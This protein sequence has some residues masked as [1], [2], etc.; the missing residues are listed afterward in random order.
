VERARWGAGADEGQVKRSDYSRPRPSAQA[1][2]QD[3]RVRRLTVNLHA[4]GP[5]PL[6]ELL[7]ELVEVHGIGDD[8]LDRLEVYYGLSD[9]AVESLGGREWPPAPLTV[10]AGRQA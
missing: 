10:L 9:Y 3:P 6:G 2:H 4:L 1:L 7:L 5:R 8:V